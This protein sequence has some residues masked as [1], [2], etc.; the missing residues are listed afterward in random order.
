MRLTSKCF[1]IVALI[2]AA[3]P[4]FGAELLL[5][6][7]GVPKLPII[8]SPKASDDTKAVAKE[9]AGY[10]KRVIQNTAAGTP[11]VWTYQKS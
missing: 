10:L 5:A 11:D 9:L 6:E 3:F 8:L 2:C 1:F 4:S 7:N